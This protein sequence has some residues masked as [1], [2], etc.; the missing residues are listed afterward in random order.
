[1]GNCGVARRMNSASAMENLLKQVKCRNFNVIYHVCRIRLG[2]IPS[3]PLH[4]LWAFI[5]WG[6][7]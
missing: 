1:M 2:F 5:F 4:G 3:Y 7:L 6:N